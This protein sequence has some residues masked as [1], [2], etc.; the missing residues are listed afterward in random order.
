MSLCVWVMSDVTDNI[1]YYKVHLVLTVLCFK[2]KHCTNFTVL[3][4][5]IIHRYARIL[6]FVLFY[7]YICRPLML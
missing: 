7:M 1:M 2:C 4:S 3:V 5:S 6:N